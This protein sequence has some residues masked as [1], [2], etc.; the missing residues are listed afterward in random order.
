MH[1][2]YF[3]F[4]ISNHNSLKRLKTPTYTGRIPGSKGQKQAKTKKQTTPQLEAI[5]S[6]KSKR[7]SGFSSIYNLAQ[8][9]I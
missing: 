4:L 5:H 8:P 7:E 9:Q 3:F 2:A 1:D 6:R